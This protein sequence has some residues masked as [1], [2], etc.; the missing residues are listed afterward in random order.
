ML[1]IA[2]ELEVQTL[3]SIGEV[4]IGGFVS[5]LGAQGLLVYF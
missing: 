3:F 4:D 2:I 1:P 5:R